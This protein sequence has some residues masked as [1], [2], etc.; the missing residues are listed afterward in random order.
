MD[1]KKF[2]KIPEGDG[3][4]ARGQTATNHQT[5]KN[6]TRVSYD[7][8]HSLVDDHSR[9]AYLEVL[10]D[11]KGPTCAAFLARAAAYFA[12]AP[13]LFFLPGQ[14]LMPNI[15]IQFDQ[16][17]VDGLLSR[18]PRLADTVFE[19][20]QQRKIVVRKRNEIARSHSH[21]LLTLC[22]GSCAVATAR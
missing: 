17:S 13:S 3:W 19:R 18:H 1:V 11:E 20:F 8:V 14:D 15:S 22:T 16:F 6:K 12:A 9:F 10:T 7:Y 21:T 4:R 5:R 2:G